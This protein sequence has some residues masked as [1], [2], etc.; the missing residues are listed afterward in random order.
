M[1]EFAESCCCYAGHSAVMDDVQCAEHNPDF[2]R[3]FILSDLFSWIIFTGS[4]MRE[5]LC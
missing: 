4:E 2:P 5:T 3:V 1:N